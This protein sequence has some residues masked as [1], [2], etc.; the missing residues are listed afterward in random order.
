MKKD[1]STILAAVV[2]IVLVVGGYFMFTQCGSDVTPRQETQQATVTDP[3][4]EGGG[5]STVSDKNKQ[6]IRG[7]IDKLADDPVPQIVPDAR[8]DADPPLEDYFPKGSTI[9]ID[10]DSWTPVDQKTANV[11][12]DL[13]SGEEQRHYKLYF[14]IYHDEWKLVYADNL[15]VSDS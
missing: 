4:A 8:E 9:T 15:S 6:M 3:D 10:E 12:V 13:T 1:P 5:V 2:P 7:V 14:V 11:E